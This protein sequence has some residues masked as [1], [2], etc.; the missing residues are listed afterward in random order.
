MK[1]DATDCKWR[2][3]YMS[4]VERILSG[5]KPMFSREGKRNQSIYHP[6]HVC[7][8]CGREFNAP[9]KQVT[10]SYGCAIARRER[11]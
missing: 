1:V 8:E 5:K 2:G 10:C 7:P 4:D 9:K 3:P 6:L 11:G